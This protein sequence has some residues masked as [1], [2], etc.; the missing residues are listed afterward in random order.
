MVH[1][2]RDHRTLSLP[3]P[4]FVHL[5]VRLSM[6]PFV[7]KNQNFLLSLISHPHLMGFGQ[8][9]CCGSDGAV[10]FSIRLDSCDEKAKKP[11]FRLFAQLHQLCAIFGLKKHLPHIPVLSQLRWLI[12]SAGAFFDVE[13]TKFVF[14]MLRPH[15]HS[16]V[17]HLYLIHPSFSSSFIFHASILYYSIE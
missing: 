10:R 17:S 14:F 4:F 13:I 3:P 12:C 11:A 9:W 6:C 8:C 2:H 1:L 7:R 15:F 16:T 5:S